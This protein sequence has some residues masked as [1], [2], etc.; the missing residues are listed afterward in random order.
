[1][2]QVLPDLHAM[3]KANKLHQPED[4]I[5]RE[6]E[7]FV[8][9]LQKSKAKKQASEPLAQSLKSLKKVSGRRDS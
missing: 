4:M 9:P 2:T 3:L 6:L 5:V 1:M 8:A 7:A